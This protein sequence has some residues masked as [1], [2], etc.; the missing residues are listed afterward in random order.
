MNRHRSPFPA[1]RRAAWAAGALLAVAGCAARPRPDPAPPPTV[2]AAAAGA[3]RRDTA[4]HVASTRLRVHVPHPDECG[5][6]N[7]SLNLVADALARFHRDRA[8]YPD[9]LRALLRMEVPPPYLPAREDWFVD[10]WGTELRYR[11]RGPGYELRAAGP[12]RAFDTADDVVESRG[13]GS[14]APGP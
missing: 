11:R 10:G 6:T 3:C 12:D 2:D 4:W 7:R 14:P 8:S 1:A 5:A 9:S 13:A